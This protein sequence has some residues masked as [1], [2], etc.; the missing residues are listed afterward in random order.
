MH[1][2]LLP[3]DRT[4]N[5]QQ[6]IC[7]DDFTV[8]KVKMRHFYLP[9]TIKLS[10]YFVTT[11]LFS[12]F[13][14]N[15]IITPYWMLASSVQNLFIILLITFGLGVLWSLNS[16]ADVE[17]KF[18]I[19]HL[20]GI[21]LAFL[22]V[23]ALNCKTLASVI[24]WRG[25]EDFH[26]L[27]TLNLVERIPGSWYLI[28]FL[29]FGLILYLVW[30]QSYL[31]IF[32]GLL[33]IVSAYLL[34]GL[35]NPFIGLDEGFLTRYPFGNYWIYSII[36]K[37]ATLIV[38][39]YQEVLYRIIPAFS[40]AALSW[41][42]L[43]D[44]KNVPL[45][46]LMIWLFVIITMP[47]LFYYASIEYLELP[48]VYLMLIV[49]SQIN[50]LVKGDVHSLKNNP[51]W[52]ALILMG[53][54]KE[55]VLPFLGCFLLI[56]LIYSLSQ[57]RNGGTFRKSKKIYTKLDRAMLRNLLNELLIAFSVLF[58]VVLYLYLRAISE[59][60]TRSFTL[61]LFNLLDPKIY[62]V[63]GQALVDQIG[64]FLLFFFLGCVLLI[65]NKQNLSFLFFI[66]SAL[67]TLLFFSIDC[68]LFIGYSRFNLF[69]LP[70]ILMGSKKFIDQLLTHNKV[71]NLGLA[72]LA[73]AAN[74]F[75]SPIN[76]DGTKKPL[77]GSY[78]IDTAEHYY[79]YKDALS[80]L[81][82]KHTNEE[83]LIAGA[84]YPYDALDFYFNQLNW[85]PKYTQVLEKNLYPANGLTCVPNNVS[86]L[87][88][89]EDVLGVL[90]RAEKDGYHV[91]LYHLI[92]D[93]IPQLEHNNHFRLEKVI[94]NEAHVLLIYYND[95]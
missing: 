18:D 56:R 9:S 42:I 45:F 59:A 66:S 71:M 51:G 13:A 58:P 27:K 75:Q 46:V 49:C 24:P 53:F 73:I 14:L 7:Q 4:R 22:L 10:R 61:N 60:V 88:N 33:T 11:L 2:T 82:E 78:L 94:R 37:V 76:F 3:S 68:K 17:I 47:I 38:N 44:R 34:F 54:I 63:I 95:R 93:R 36:P 80:W 65:H 83:I 30:K 90:A 16:G 72:L 85:Q 67:V 40:V 32:V 19:R 26:L 92:G 20:G 74:L 70:P 69:L 25:D 28:G 87:S 84:Y 91:I 52:Y 41:I 89:Y 6:K 57:W 62:F 29:L 12:F 15:F 5:E 31:A 1:L 43:S 23:I 8:E 55:T 21:A 86:D 48:A 64:I 39:P 50:D 77:W 35:A 79:P 81:K